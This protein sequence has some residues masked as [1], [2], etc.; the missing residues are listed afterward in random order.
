VS[1]SRKYGRPLVAAATVLGL[2]VGFTLPAVGAP[3]Y[4][5]HALGAPAATAGPFRTLG[6]DPALATLS[7]VAG[8]TYLIE[9]AERDNDALV[10]ILGVQ[11][12]VLASADHP[13]RRT[14]IRRALVT[15]PGTSLVVRVTGKERADIAG[16]ASIRAFDIADASAPAECIAVYRALTRADADFAEG[17]RLAHGTQASH[18]PDARAAFARAASGFTAAAQALTAPEDRELRGQAALAVAAI[19][20]SNL[21]DWSHAA[22]WAETAAAAFAGVDSYRHAR[23]Q[24]L[25]ATSWMEIGSPALLQ[26]S[27]AALQSVSLL[28]L[29]RGERYDAALQTENLALV[30]LFQGR[31]PEC[32]ATSVSAARLFG[33]IQET[34][35]RVQAWQNQALCLWGEGRLSEALRWFQQASREVLPGEIPGL[36]LTVTNNTALLNYEL[37]HF[38]EALS[39]FDRALAFAQQV[40]DARNEARSFYGIGVTYYAIGDRERARQFLERALVIRTAAFDGRGRMATL[41]ALANV[42]AEQGKLEQALNFDA[43]AL[44]LAV[45]PSALARIRIQTAVH[46]GQAGHL[47]EALAR[48]SEV[49]ADRSTDTLIRAEAQ[50]QRA[51]V[52]REL[53]RPMDARLDLM[54]ARPLL[55][56]RGSAAEEFQADLEL[57]R[58]LRTGA[59]PQEAL[60]ALDEALAHADAVREQ[61]ANPELRM[62]LGTPLRAAYEL[63]VEL[64]RARFETA[65]ASGDSAAAAGLA[66]AAFLAADS[67]R[68]RSLADFAAQEYLPGV[69]TAL[70]GD[71]ARRTELYRQMAARRF[72]LE[73]R[74]DRVGSEDPQVRRLVAEI[75]DLERQADAVNTEIARR[76]LAADGTSHN[77]GEGLPRLSAKQALAAYWLGA[78]S[79]Y[80]WVILPGSVEWTR[81]PATA[82]IEDA[83]AKFHR[84]LT[85]LVDVPLERRLEDAQHLYRMIV[86]PVEQVLAPAQL[87]IIIPDRGLSYVPFAAL[88][89]AETGTGGFVAM[90]HDIAIAPAA[91]LM[92]HERRRAYIPAPRKLLLIDDPVYQPDDPRLQALKKRVPAQVPPEIAIANAPY[93][94]LRRLP[95]TAEEA[96]RILAQ[97]SHAQVDELTGLQA[98]RGRALA[99]DWSQYRYIH[100]AA[101]AIAD[102]QVPQLSAVILGAY[103]AQGDAVEEAVR[104]SDLSLQT[105]TSD[106]AVLS[107]CDTAVGPQVASEG[108]VG[109]ESTLLARGARAV[110]ASLWP[111]SDETSAE[112]MTDFYRHLVQDSMN[113]PAA[114][115]GA[116]RTVMARERSADPA[117]WATFQVSITALGAAGALDEPRH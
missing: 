107:A 68:A 113:A 62:Q 50:L 46:T 66:T 86:Q 80:V 1:I 17:E 110:V 57:A 6:T 88:R 71:L 108:P 47:E 65:L 52:L 112:L 39:L 14:G 5:K 83:A 90:R 76:T 13:E 22:E 19:D 49:V 24:A 37:G 11:D 42:D 7:L 103:N 96:R 93:H 100:I 70:A 67:S 63:K 72:A 74:L 58:V 15:S 109:L 95:F 16:A 73:S 10:E 34:Q 43:E 114:L 12:Q 4:C 102:G 26:R 106:V 44:Q 8:H 89:T 116:M 60:K 9:V 79:A 28:H 54:A 117:L 87:W 59:K 104:V 41:R 98:T 53:E 64:L 23:A 81:L 40:Q 33:S 2:L 30:Y 69:R 20:Y 51:V 101:H 115:G 61:T 84:S 78:E 18:S 75:A 82:S 111:V 31:Y 94:E 35:R 45:A 105:L 36:Y 25:R 32:V 48:L 92:T 56:A 91:W 77:A 27:G 38:D 55:H 97:F 21:Q 85:R 99:L 29:R 3:V